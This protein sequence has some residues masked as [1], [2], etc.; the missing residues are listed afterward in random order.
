[1][2]FRGEWF[3]LTA[4]KQHLVKGLIYPVPDPAFPWLG[5]HFTLRTDGEIWLGPNA[6]MATAREGYKFTNIN[7][8]DMYEA[9]TFK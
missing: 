3:K 1:M 7:I 2:P 5:V 9:I 4:E 8:K 6:I